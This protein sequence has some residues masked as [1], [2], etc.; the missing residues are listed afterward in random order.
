MTKCAK[1]KGV[2]LNIQD[3]LNDSLVLLVVIVIATPSQARANKPATEETPM[4]D[5]GG[6]VRRKTSLAAREH[7]RSAAKDPN[8]RVF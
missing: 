8:I 5:V 6:E 7:H 4:L 2:P 1:F 3:N